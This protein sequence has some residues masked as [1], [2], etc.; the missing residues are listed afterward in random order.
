MYTAL[1]V[2]HNIYPSFNSEKKIFYVIF[3]TKHFAY[4]GK[5]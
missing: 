2:M 3:Q 4:G 1:L 5:S